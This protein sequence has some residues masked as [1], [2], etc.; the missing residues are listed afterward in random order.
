MR[1]K[2]SR[3]NILSILSLLSSWYNYYQ[4]NLCIR[5]PLNMANV[6][7]Y[8]MFWPSYE[9]LFKSEEKERERHLTCAQKRRK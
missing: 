1:S 5:P 9:V 2:I 3:R 7:S 4:K 8:N 6:T